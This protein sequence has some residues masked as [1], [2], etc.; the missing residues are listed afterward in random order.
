MVCLVYQSMLN[1]GIERL[2][3]VTVKRNMK[4]HYEQNT[5]RNRYLLSSLAKLIRDLEDQNITVVP[6]KGV[7]LLTTVYCQDP[8]VRLL[9]DIDLLAAASN[10]TAIHTYMKENSFFSY[11]INDQDALCTAEAEEMSHFYISFSEVGLQDDLRIDVDYTYP[12]EVLEKLGKK[13]NPVFEFCFL[14]QAYYASMKK[15][16]LPKTVDQFNYV[17]LV[18]IFE[19]CKRFLPHMTNTEL[20]SAAKSASCANQV[21]YALQCLARLHED[22]IIL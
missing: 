1:L 2:L 3:P 20:E 5:L 4:Y 13:N 16:G 19:F 6:V 21:S 18:D 15:I 10:R 7:K 22:P 12:Q 11:L 17:K 8:G 14:C 9:N